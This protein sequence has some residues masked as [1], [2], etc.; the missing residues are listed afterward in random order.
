MRA[1]TEIARVRSE[2]QGADL[3]DQVMWRIKLL[4]GDVDL[5]DGENREAFADVLDG[6]VPENHALILNPS[7]RCRATLDR[8]G[9]IVFSGFL[10]SGGN[11]TAE[12]ERRLFLGRRFAEHRR[13]RV[14]PRFRGNKIAPRSLIRSV[15]LYDRLQ[16][17]YVTLRAAFSGSWYWAQWGFHFEDPRELERMQNHAQWIIDAFG[18]GED[19]RTLTHPVQIYRL[20]E[21]PDRPGEPVMIT[22]DQ[23]CDALPQCREAYEEIAYDNGLGMH[24]PVPFGRIVFMT[25]PAWSA[26]LDLDGADRL[27]FNDRA[28]RVLGA[29]GAA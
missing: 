26:R 10:V 16:F 28:R 29:E 15:A 6:F 19:A 5:T 24:D 12:I 13:I 11:A 27:I 4:G 21:P 2:K 8:G 3:H 1:H 7:A 14:V 17:E 23:L 9:E 20:S 22:F 25:G 18:G